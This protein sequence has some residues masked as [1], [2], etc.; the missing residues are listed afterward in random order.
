[1]KH[2]PQCRSRSRQRTIYFEK[3]DTGSITDDKIKADDKLRRATV[4]Q[5]KA[6]NK[7]YFEVFELKFY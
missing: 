5:T 1:M 3:K 6:E 7:F 2:I 4:K